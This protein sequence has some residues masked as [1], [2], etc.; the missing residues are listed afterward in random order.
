M[1][2]PIT[3]TT[4]IKYNKLLILFDFQLVMNCFCYKDATYLLYLCYSILV[5]CYRIAIKILFYN[6]SN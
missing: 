4:A 2:Q 1:A 6:I 3:S 5:D